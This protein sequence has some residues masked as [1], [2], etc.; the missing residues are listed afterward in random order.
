MNFHYDSPIRI[1]IKDFHDLSK[2][3]NREKKRS[4][5]RQLILTNYSAPLNIYEITLIAFSFR[6]SIELV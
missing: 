1:L 5:L 4:Q 2:Q 3:M 6:M